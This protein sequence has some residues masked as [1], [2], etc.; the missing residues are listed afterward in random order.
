MLCFT[1][2]SGVPACPEIVFL[3]LSDK[4]TVTKQV[5]TFPLAAGTINWVSSGFAVDTIGNV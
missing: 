4:S 5:L 2:F 3:I 1:R